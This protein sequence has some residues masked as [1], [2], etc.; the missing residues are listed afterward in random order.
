MFTSFQVLFWFRA[1]EELR[2][3][4]P[5]YLIPSRIAAP[6]LQRSQTRDDSLIPAYGAGDAFVSTLGLEI[7]HPLPHIAAPS[8]AKARDGCLAP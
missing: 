6:I 7:H 4:R 3:P 2:P 1:N 8:G 5:R